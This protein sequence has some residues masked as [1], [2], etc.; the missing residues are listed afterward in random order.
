MGGLVRVLAVPIHNGCLVLVEGEEV[1]GPFKC[2]WRGRHTY[3]PSFMERHMV[4]VGR[5][6]K[7][8]GK[9]FEYTCETCGEKTGWIRK[10]KQAQWEL[11]HNPSWSNKP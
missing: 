2:W 11:E 1:I 10:S 3:Y 7:H 4:R 8:V 9:E 5:H 6:A